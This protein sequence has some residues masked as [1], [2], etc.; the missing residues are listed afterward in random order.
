MAKFNYH[1]NRNDI[2]VFYDYKWDSKVFQIDIEP[3]NKRTQDI[4]L[5]VKYFSKKIG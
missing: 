1:E 5:L 2:V 4:P 3:L